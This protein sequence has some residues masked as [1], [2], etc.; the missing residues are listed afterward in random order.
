[1]RTVTLTPELLLQLVKPGSKV[2]INVP[3]G[4]S[5]ERDAAGK[6]T[7]KIVQDWKESTGKA[8]IVTRQNYTGP[9]THVALNMGGRFGTPGVAT[10][11]NIVAVGG[12]RASR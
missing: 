5:I 7:G 8:V 11:E 1:M 4:K 9:I 10:V 2:T 6:S 3:N 12:K